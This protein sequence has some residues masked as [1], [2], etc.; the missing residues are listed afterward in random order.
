MEIL[1]P[2]F[3]MFALTV[4][5]A[6]I[7]VIKRFDAVAKKRIDPRYY[8]VYQGATE[9]EDVAVFT[10]HLSN[11]FEQ[12]VLFYTVVLAAYATGQAGGAMVAVAWAYVVARYLHSAVHLLGNQVL[13]RV[14]VF[15]LSWIALT[16]LWVMLGMGIAG[17]QGV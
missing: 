17:R 4:T 15:T 2:L 6:V 5:V 10:R 8:K 12:P 14:R 9:P 3:A 7:L 13:W 11:L 16:A 1:W